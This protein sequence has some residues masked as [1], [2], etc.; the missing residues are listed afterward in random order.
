MSVKIKHSGNL[1][2]IIY[3]LNAMESASNLRDDSVILFIELNKPITLHPSFKHPL[4]GVMMNE[5][6][7]KMAKPFF[8]KFDFIEDVLVYKNQKVDYDFDRFREINFNLSG[9]NIK[10]WYIYAYPE[11]QLYF[12][13]K[14]I[15]KW[16]T[17]GGNYVVLNR[18]ERYNN[19]FID[20]SIL[21]TCT[22]PIYFVGTNIE[23]QLIK[24]VVPDLKF[25]NCEDFLEL[26]YFIADSTL[27]IGNQSMCFA[28]AEQIGATTLLEVAPQCPNVLP[29]TGFEMFTQEGFEYSLKQYNLI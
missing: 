23:Y 18:T 20:Y 28:I 17:V 19:P 27:F 9:G 22:Q 15:V 2:D 29:T 5:Y 24:K 11:L 4:N 14:N 12:H 1:G 7:F 13:D 3:S 21:K 10:R 26:A 25:F 16:G 6:M 8:K